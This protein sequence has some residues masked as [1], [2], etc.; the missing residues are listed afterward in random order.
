MA[1]MRTHA[2]RFPGETSRYRTARNRLLEAERDLRR[3]VEKVAIMRRKFIP[4]DFA[5]FRFPAVP[6]SKSE[7]IARAFADSDRFSV[8]GKRGSCSTYW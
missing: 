1:A 6:D 4:E 7:P 8:R 3:Q 5:R 2:M